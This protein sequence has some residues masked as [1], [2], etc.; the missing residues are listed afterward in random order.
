MAVIRTGESA[1]RRN[2]RAEL[3]AERLSGVPSNGFTSAPMQWGIDNEPLARLAYELQSGNTV[4]DAFFETHKT[5]EAGASPDGYIGKDGLIEI[6]CPNTAT[7]IET[8]KTQKLPK[9]YYA[10]VQGQLWITNRQWCDFLS[11]DP[12]LPDNAQLYLVRVERDESFIKDLEAEV[13][14]FLR[15]VEEEV[16]FIKEYKG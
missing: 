5:L 13:T 7:H 16:N 11:F 8:L 4:E 3:V 15:E 14:K 12:R 2:Y 6:K 1:Q 9:Q 10:Q